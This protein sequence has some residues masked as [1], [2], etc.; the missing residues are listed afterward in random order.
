[1]RF[2]AE[3]QAKYPKAV[4]SLTANWERLVS[5]FDFPAE[6]W[7]HLRTTNVI[8][9]A[10]ATVRLRERATKG[11]G[12]RSKGLLMAFKLLDMAQQRWRRLDGA[13]SCR[14]SES[15]R[16]NLTPEPL[17]AG[18]HFCLNRISQGAPNPSLLHTRCRHGRQANST[19][20]RCRDSGQVASY[21]SGWRG[22]RVRPEGH[23]QRLQNMAV[24]WPDSR[25]DAPNHDCMVSRDLSVKV[26]PPSPDEG[27]AE[28]GGAETLL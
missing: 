7:K 19:A 23:S 3:Y 1:M 4:A 14:W 16:L 12:S 11:A 24:G 15:R 22:N 18:Q 6:H 9:S 21:Y 13:S 2:A 17:S 25:T 27:W 8:E 5:F 28:K 20:Y 10:F 26:V